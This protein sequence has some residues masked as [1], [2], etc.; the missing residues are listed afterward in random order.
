MSTKNINQY[1]PSFISKTPMQ[2]WIPALVF[3]S[4]LIV[5]L[6]VAFFQTPTMTEDQR[7]IMLLLFALLAGFS[8]FFLGGTAL[9]EIS[10]KTSQGTKITLSA[11]AGIAVF[12]LCYLYPPYFISV[13]NTASNRNSAPSK[14]AGVNPMLVG[15]W[16]LVEEVAGIPKKSTWEFTDD[17]WV[18][19]SFKNENN[20]KDYKYKGSYRVNGDKI[21]WTL[22]FDG[23]HVVKE[24]DTIEIQTK[25]KVI[26][27]SPEDRT[28][29]LEKL[30]TE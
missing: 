21:T 10:E 16:R 27:R 5:F 13:S 19:I 20:G 7:R 3:V 8:T 22:S 18:I 4:S 23:Q 30:I 15:V 1:R 6:I 26:M 28:M 25:D 2:I 12:V 11:T 29:Q 9:L 17:G 14:L 24:T